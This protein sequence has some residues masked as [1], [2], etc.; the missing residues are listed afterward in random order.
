[1][2]LQNPEKGCFRSG[3]NGHYLQQVT[4]VLGIFAQVFMDEVP[5]LLA[6]K[7]R[8]PLKPNEDYVGESPTGDYRI[9]VILADAGCQSRGHERFEKL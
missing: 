5:A 3:Q 2:A 6:R 4:D 7:S 1:M 9:Y 8:V